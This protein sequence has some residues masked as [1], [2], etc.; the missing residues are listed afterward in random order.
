MKQRIIFFIYPSGCFVE[1]ERFS[2]V[3][4]NTNSQAAGVFIDLA[5]LYTVSKHLEEQIDQNYFA[6]IT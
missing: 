4:D 3:F 2:W 6:V 5:A 1:T